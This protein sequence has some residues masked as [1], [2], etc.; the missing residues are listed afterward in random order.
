M[1]RIAIAAFLSVAVFTFLVGASMAQDQPVSAPESQREPKAAQVEYP[2]AGYR[3]QTEDVMKITVWG[4]PNLSAEQVVDPEGYINMPLL[5]Q[6]HVEGLALSEL[7]D[8]LKEGLNEY[9]VE[10]KVQVAMMQFRK[11]K[12]HVLGQVNRPGLHEFKIG[13]KV[14]E[15]IAKAG[16]FTEAAHL[17]GAK[18]THSDS[19]ESL[20]LD[21]RKLFY[22]GD[23]SKNLVLQDGD[24]IYIPED[25]TNKY[26]VLGQVLRPGFFRLKED[27][28]VIDAISTAGGPTERG[29]L[30]DA[31]IIRGDPNN[32]E[33]VQVNVEKIIKS[34]DMTQNL[35]LQPGDVVYV[36]ETS[37]LDWREISNIVSSV[38]NSS[39]LLRM[40]GLW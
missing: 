33:R 24:T 23:M 7:T 10:P 16:S 35:K 1:K 37:K 27:V 26:F 9:L 14:M 12:V 18:L 13:D 40:W 5:G 30:K 36:P 20:P 39:Y 28:T 19:E 2:P 22:E 21:L 32:P 17:E 25:T 15:A 3:I 38:V 34:A 4:E 31:C 8:K 11:P 6:L 29:S